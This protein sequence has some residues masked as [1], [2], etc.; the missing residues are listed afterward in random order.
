MDNKGNR[1]RVNNAIVAGFVLIGAALAIIVYFAG[2][3][4]PVPSLGLFVA[5]SGMGVLGM[6]LAYSDAQVKF[7][8]SERGFRLAMGALITAVGA[9]MVLYQLGLEWY[10]YIA[11]VLIAVAA[12]GM[13][14]AL[15]NGKRMK[16]D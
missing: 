4:D 13:G 5:L 9:I 12:I 8:P 7:G 1:Y 14:M 16:E 6:S 10:F 11:A 15:M 2:L 3:M